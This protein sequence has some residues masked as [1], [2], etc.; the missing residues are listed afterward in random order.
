MAV[1]ALMEGQSKLGMDVTLVTGS[2]IGPSK[3]AAFARAGVQ[4][5]SHS[6]VGPAAFRNYLGLAADIRRLEPSIVH[7]HSGFVPLHPL[8][9]R[10]GTQPFVVTPHGAYARRVTRRGYL[11]KGIYLAL[12]EKPFLARAGALIA[13]TADEASDAARFG[14]TDRVF[15]VPNA[16]PNRKMQDADEVAALR[17][18]KRAG[19]DPWR[20]VF[21]G[22]LDVE[23]KGLDLLA[24]VVRQ[25][26][27]LGIPMR[28]SCYGP[29][30]R[31][32]PHELSRLEGASGGALTFEEPVYGDAKRDVFVAADFYIQLSRWEAFG[33]AVAEAMASGLPTVVSES[34][35]IAA[36][37]RVADAAE[38][39]PCDVASII[40]RLINLFG[41]Q[42][43]RLEH[44]SLRGRTF[45]RKEYSAGSVAERTRAAYQAALDGVAPRIGSP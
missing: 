40:D 19:G 13:L 7:Y 8:M 22:R 15:V 18:C 26:N 4:V 41:I 24:D 45:V 12:L 16:L 17:A 9:A 10:I 28:V 11:K 21:L 42:R 27:L 44:L 2:S 5:I 36:D 35:S 30:H 3:R 23:N 39:V 6:V 34:M 1:E 31:A 33:M 38:V 25:M 29:R 32:S 37:L 20:G 43:S 14:L